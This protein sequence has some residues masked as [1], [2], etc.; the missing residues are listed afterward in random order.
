MES[1]QVEIT[2]NLE[3]Q[4]DRLN[5][6]LADLMQNYDSEAPTLET[7]NDDDNLDIK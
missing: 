6:I 1:V 5:A 3:D 4:V 7:E 2:E